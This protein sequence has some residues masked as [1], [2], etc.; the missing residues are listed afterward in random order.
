[1]KAIVEETR[2][3]YARYRRYGHTKFRAAI[4]AVP[5][6]LFWKTFAVVAVV[7]GLAWGIA[8]CLER[9]SK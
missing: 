6:D 7:A 3:N 4:M 1:M 9:L 8:A 5:A 2:H